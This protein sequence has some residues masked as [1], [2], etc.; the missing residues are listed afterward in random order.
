MIAAFGSFAASDA[1]FATLGSAAQPFGAGAPE[2]SET[3]AD[4]DAAATI[5]RS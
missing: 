2:A 5:S 1:A 3:S 4:T